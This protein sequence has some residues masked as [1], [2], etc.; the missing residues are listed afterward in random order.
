VQLAPSQAGEKWRIPIPAQYLHRNWDE[1]IP[2]EQNKKGKKRVKAVT[3][4]VAGA[5]ERLA[6]QVHRLSPS[7]LSV[8]R[9]FQLFSGLCTC[10]A[11][12]CG[13]GAPRSGG[14]VLSSL[15]GA[16]CTARQT[17][18][19]CNASTHLVLVASIELV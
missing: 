16:L 9:S 17:L 13:R 4:D 3:A 15:H 5:A 12:T 14:A 11:Q 1:V 10:C 7:G 2:P 18:L 8:G 6:K 19:L